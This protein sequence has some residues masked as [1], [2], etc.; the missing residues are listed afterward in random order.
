MV[1]LDRRN[2]AMECGN[3]G[4]FANETNILSEHAR[5]LPDREEAKK[6]VAEMKKQVSKIWEETVLASG[7]SQWDV[8]AIRSAFVYP[9]F[10]Y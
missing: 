1:S 2:L 4:R 10:S 9:G 8:E 3:Q 5:F 7:A 6:I